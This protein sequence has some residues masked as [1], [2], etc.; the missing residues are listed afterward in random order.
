MALGDGYLTDFNRQM[1]ESFNG[2]PSAPGVFH[3]VGGSF[4][5]SNSPYPIGPN[6]SDAAPPTMD[7]V[8]GI[9]TQSNRIGGGLE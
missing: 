7:T 4:P 9:T 5:G 8:W 3:R 6:N 1:P 2:P